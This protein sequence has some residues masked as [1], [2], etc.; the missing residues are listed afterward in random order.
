ME[1]TTHIGRNKT[2][3]KSCPFDAHGLIEAAEQAP[4]LPERAEAALIA[5]KL[6]YARNADALGSVPPPATV[7]GALKSGTDALKGKRPQVVFDKIAERLAFERTGVRLYEAIIIKH[8]AHP[9]VGS[10]VPMDELQKFQHAEAEHFRLLVESTEYLGG[11]PTAQTPCAAA[12][13]VAGM[14]WVQ[15]ANEPRS[16]FLQS[17]QVILMAELAD[18]DGWNTLCSV[19]NAAGHKNLAERFQRA[20]Q[21]EVR[22][23]DH[24]RRWMAALTKAELGAA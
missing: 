15:L 24:V 13:G 16:T 6:D 9:D 4:A 2:G 19:M 23:L 7:K 14:G 20:E 1:P 22:H 11:D 21:E 5:L 18:V 12:I 8:I 3:I 10:L 17:L